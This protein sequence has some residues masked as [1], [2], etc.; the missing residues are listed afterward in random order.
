MLISSHISTLHTICTILHTIIIGG[1]AIHQIGIAMTYVTCGTLFGVITIAN[2]LLLKETMHVSSCAK[3]ILP[4]TPAAVSS[5]ASASV[6]VNKST[7]PRVSITTGGNQ[8][9]VVTASNAIPISAPT[10]TAI[11]PTI[12]TTAASVPTSTTTTT[13]T[14]DPKTSAKSASP[15]KSSHGLL[16][17]FRTAFK[18]WQ[19][20][21]HDIK[22]MN[23]SILNTF[24]W[25][26]LAGVQMTVL[27]LYMVSPLF[28]LGPAQIGT[29]YVTT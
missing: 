16:Q 11:T 4:P 17:S 13:P 1:L 18:E 5:T 24:Y 29:A 3:R 22:L 21:S 19:V 9:A 12:T 6:V 26:S 20:L 28:D 15:Q 14:A 2:Q 23:M 25:A 27:P 7:T 10:T 8:A